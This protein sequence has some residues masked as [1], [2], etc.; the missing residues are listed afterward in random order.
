MVR[1]IIEEGNR[2]S[3][4]TQP[5]ERR[6]EKEETEQSVGRVWKELRHQA[7]EEK[8]SKSFAWDSEPEGAQE[9]RRARPPGFMA[10]IQGPANCLHGC[11]WEF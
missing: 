10:A 4:K 2:G 5:E 7:A 6:E 9:R 11:L 1:E 3:E 8:L